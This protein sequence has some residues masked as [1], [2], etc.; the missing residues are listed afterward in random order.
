MENET[1]RLLQEAYQALADFSVKGHYSMVSISAL[2]REIDRHL[3]VENNHFADASKMEPKALKTQEGGI[4]KPVK[5]DGSTASYYELPEGATELQ[6]LISYRVM[7][8][9]NGEI[10]YTH[11][12]LERLEALDPPCEARQHSDQMY[13]SSCETAWDMNDPYP[14]L[15]KN[16]EIL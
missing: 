14:P 13:C 2:C 11:A 7:N 15:C 4:I 5:S 1:E 16:K 6:H 12:E 10:F 3:S 8:A 9:Q